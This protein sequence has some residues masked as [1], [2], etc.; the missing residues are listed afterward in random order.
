[1]AARFDASPQQR[2]NNL[3][4]SLRLRENDVQEA[5]AASRGDVTAAE[6]FLRALARRPIRT[7]STRE[8]RIKRAAV[9]LARTPDALD[10][11][12]L[13]LK[14]VLDQP[15][16]ERL[17]KVKVSDGPFKERV[18]SKNK[19]GVEL[20]YAVG[21][22]PMH[23]HLVL[24]SHDPA[25]LTLAL[26]ELS[27][28]RQLSPYIEGKVALQSEQARLKAVA[29]D[30]ADAAAQR[31]AFLAK[32]PDEPSG[33]NDGL[34]ACVISVKLAGRPAD[35]ARIATRRF[36]SDNTLLDL[37]HYVSSLPDVPLGGSVRLEN[38]T[39]RPARV[40]DPAEHGSTSLYALDLWPRG[41]VQVTPVAA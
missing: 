14:R 20:L 40:L 3:A 12:H 38:V 37:L 11:L 8:E 30:A 16:V 41:Q 26:N 31:A 10:I 9:A 2:L 23:G 6:R 36:H 1:M 15:D 32:V 17:R 33:E 39:T 5:L 7:P 4:Q 22:E 19:A 29:Q 18:A 21:Y 24:Q 13:S 35:E 28:A 25:V 27:S 34:S